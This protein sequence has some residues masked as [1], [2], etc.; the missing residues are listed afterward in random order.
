MPQC[1]MISVAPGWRSTSPRSPS[2]IGG[3][4]R[5]PWIRIGTRALGGER[6]HRLEPRVARG[7]LLRARMQLDPAGAE[8]EAAR[9]LLDRRL[10]Q[11]EADERD[12]PAAAA[13]RERERSVVRGAEAGVPVGLVEAEHEGARDAVARHQRLEAVVVADHPVDVEAEVQVRVEDVG[14]LRQQAAE[15]LVVHA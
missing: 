15:L 6:E 14:A 4:P 10:V 1:A 12:Q 5:P 3:R 8:V 2:A 7:E 13:L 11:V 9:R